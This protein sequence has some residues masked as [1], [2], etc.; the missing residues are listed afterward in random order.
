[1]KFLKRIIFFFLF[2]FVHTYSFICIAFASDY[3]ISSVP[4]SCLVAIDIGHSK[5]RCGATSSR[6]VGEYWFNSAI[7]KKLHAKLIENDLLDVV[8]INK[9]GS[10][11]SLGQRVS[12]INLS[13]ADLVISI[14][15]DSVQPKYLQKWN[16]NGEPRN[17]CDTFSGHSIFISKKSIEHE[18][19]LKLAYMIGNE[20]AAINL[21]PTLH[22]SEMIP[23]E[24]RELI[25][26]DLGIYDADFAVL[27]KTTIPSVLVEC[28]IIINRIDEEKLINND[29]QDI[30]AGAIS[31]GIIN[32]CLKKSLH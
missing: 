14:H 22:H 7:A 12:E 26:P 13:K 5:N 4:E 29:Y 1:M 20:F 16:F 32:Y 27:K 23:G 31:S 9:K 17:Y 2:F 28:G 15:H 6:G 24:S 10:E 30:I 19:S 21:N 25:S 18:K 3:L 11:V 8:I